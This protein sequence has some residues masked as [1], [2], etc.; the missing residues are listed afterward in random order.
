[1]E[2][3]FVKV[4]SAVPTVK[5]AD[6]RHNAWQM[7][8]M[9]ADAANQNVEIIIFPELS[10]T[11]YTCGD[12]FAQSVLLEEAEKSLEWLVAETQ[13][14]PVIS[15]VGIPPWCSNQAKFLE[16][17]LRHSFPTIRNFTKNAGL[18]QP[19]KPQNA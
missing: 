15:I 11:G 7:A 17:S 10:I 18:H 1:M 9:I 6:C 14:L 16:S 5:V 3:G 8:E 4:A 13:S 2:Y 19:C 12:L